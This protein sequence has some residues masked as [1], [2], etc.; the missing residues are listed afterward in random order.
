M[1]YSFAKTL[2]SFVLLSSYVFLPKYGFPDAHLFGHFLFSVSHANVWHLLANLL[3]LW[4]LPC[5]L[6]LCMSYL[7]A[8]F[9]SFLPCFVSEPTMGFSGI[10]F[11]VIG[12]S[13]GRVCRFREMLWKNKWFLVIPMFI[14]H[15]NAFIHV[16]CLVFGYLAGKFVHLRNTD[17]L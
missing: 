13:W 7:T 12:I 5:R 4:M 10:L 1:S 3:C 14:P 6:H 9:C 15:V 11:S 2:I 17:W 16:Y 8:L